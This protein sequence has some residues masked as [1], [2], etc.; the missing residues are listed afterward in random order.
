MVPSL[1]N[2]Q[3]VTMLRCRGCAMFET[4]SLKLLTLSYAR[5]SLIK[6][7][8]K[9]QKMKFKNEKQTVQQYGPH[10]IRR[11]PASKLEKVQSS[12]LF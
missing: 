2:T 5:G 7:I 4:V 8:D 3:S 12:R 6:F 1:S 11:L 9:L 10:T